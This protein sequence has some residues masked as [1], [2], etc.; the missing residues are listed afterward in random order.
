M[1]NGALLLNSRSPPPPHQS[2]Q[3]IVVY[4]CNAHTIYTQVT[5]WSC[6]YIIL[7][8][9]AV[10]ARDESSNVPP[11]IWCVWRVYYALHMVVVAVV[12]STCVYVIAITIR[13]ALYYMYV[14]ACVCVCVNSPQA[15]SLLGRFLLAPH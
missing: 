13:G 5:D 12:N 3:Y 9:E 14:Y 15:H 2:A 11:N 6:N 4:L 10:A 8:F 1:R 7:Q